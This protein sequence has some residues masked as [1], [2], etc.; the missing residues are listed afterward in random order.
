MTKVRCQ[1]AAALHASCVR[2]F[3]P[4]RLAGVLDMQV[5][6]RSVNEGLVIGD[7]VRVTV[8]EIQSN[9]IRLAIETP[10]QTPQ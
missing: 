2:I 4:Q 9:Y 5:I 1:N 10:R 7:D 3:F 6:A 8:L